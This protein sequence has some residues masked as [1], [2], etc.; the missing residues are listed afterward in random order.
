M[1][2]AAALEQ[3][4]PCHS[5]WTAGVV[6]GLLQSAPGRAGEVLREAAGPG[7]LGTS[8]GAGAAASSAAA[9]A[10][11][12][13]AMDAAAQMVAVGLA[14]AR[15]A[16]RV[17]ANPCCANLAGD[18]EAELVRPCRGGCGGRV[19]G[20]VRQGSA[21]HQPRVRRRRRHGHGGRVFGDDWQQGRRG[22]GGR[23]GAW[24]GG[25]ALRGP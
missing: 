5:P 23:R 8:G 14:A 19:R 11:V 6:R 13:A 18:S 10:A 12:G 9:T 16:L 17:C 7:V 21:V 15:A 24:Q 20:G 25:A 2:L 3:P 1:Q 4:G 22:W